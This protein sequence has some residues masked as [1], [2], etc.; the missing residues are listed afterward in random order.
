MG[1]MRYE[2]KNRLT[3]NVQFTAEIACDEDAV[4]RV[5]LGLAV[6]VAVKTGVYLRDADLRGADLGDADLRG[7]DLRGADLRGVYLRG[8]DL[9]GAYLRGA[10]LGDADL[11][12]ADLRDADLRG[13]YLRD[14][15]LRGAYLGDADLGGLILLSRAMRSDGYEYFAWTSILGGMVIIA[16]CR[17]WQDGSVHTPGQA[18]STARHHCETETSERYR[19]EALSIVDHIE[20]MASHAER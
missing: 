14:A 8:A 17:T 16:G 3:G 12:G 19:K 5:K 1:L 11:R 15:D 9:G 4:W 13:V 20:R 2:I 7:A 6:K 10:Y 18:I